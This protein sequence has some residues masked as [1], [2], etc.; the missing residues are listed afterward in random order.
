MPPSC[1]A[2][3][4]F[5]RFDVGCRCRPCTINFLHLISSAHCPKLHLS[6]VPTAMQVSILGKA[7]PPR[8]EGR[9][10]GTARGLVANVFA[11]F[12]Q[13]FIGPAK[14]QHSGGD[15]PSAST[16]PY[17]AVS[18]L[19]W[20]GAATSSTFPGWCTSTVFRT[21]DVLHLA[22]HHGRYCV[23]VFIDRSHSVSPLVMDIV[24]G[25]RRSTLCFAHT[26]HYSRSDNGHPSS[27][28]SPLVCPLFV[29]SPTHTVVAESVKPANNP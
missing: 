21:S 5:P 27:L 26:K 24:V 9:G 8:S 19:I 28:V 16:N 22:P 15:A 2:V 20:P 4:L 29:G 10:E 12:G 1:C 25:L 11:P 18:K 14:V 3:S 17:L 7:D 13:A 6:F 23:Q